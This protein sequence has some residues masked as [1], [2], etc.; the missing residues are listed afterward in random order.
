MTLF[1]PIEADRRK[2]VGKALAADR[3]SELLAAARG[4]AAFIARDGDTVTSDEVANLMAHNGLDYAELGNAAGSVFDGKFV[5]TGQVV[6]SRRPSS[7]GRLIRVWRL[8]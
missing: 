8:R 7:H 2:A 1:D 4:F 3:R 5:W 6:P